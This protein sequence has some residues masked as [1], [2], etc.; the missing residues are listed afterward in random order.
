MLRTLSIKHV[1]GC[2]T[3]SETPDTRRGPLAGLAAKENTYVNAGRQGSHLFCGELR[4]K[5][6]API[7]ESGFGVLL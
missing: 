2:P 4:C 1:S 6:Q 3:N 7:L 5:E